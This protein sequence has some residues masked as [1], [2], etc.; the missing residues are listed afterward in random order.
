MR[1]HFP[2]IARACC[3]DQ[4]NRA[5]CML[6]PTNF[7]TFGGGKRE[8]RPA[9]KPCVA[10]NLLGQTSQSDASDATMATSVDDHNGRDLQVAGPDS[11]LGKWS[12]STMQQPL[13]RR[14]V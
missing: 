1:R 12:V 6:S 5:T 2:R 13:K 3:A 4:P 10:N 7:R 14:P 9:G 11:V 8:S